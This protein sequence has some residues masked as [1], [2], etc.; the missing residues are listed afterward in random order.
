[1]SK[2]NR[3]FDMIEPGPKPQSDTRADLLPEWS[4]PTRAEIR[5]I[6]QAKSLERVMSSRSS[7]RLGSET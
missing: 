1:M 5:R 2:R 4:P 6:N 3:Q 7:G